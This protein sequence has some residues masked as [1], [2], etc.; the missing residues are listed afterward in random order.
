MFAHGE[1]WAIE[2]V[3]FV[4]RIAALPPPHLEHETLTADR[5]TPTT[6]T[7]NHAA[8]VNTAK[9]VVGGQVYT[10]SYYIKPYGLQRYIAS[11]GDVSA[12]RLGGFV[13]YD[14]VLGT[15]T[16]GSGATI[17][18]VGGGWFRVVQVMTAASSGNSTLAIILRNT[19]GANFESY[20]GV[21][22]NGFYLWGVQ[23]EDGA[24]ATS[25]ITTTTVAGVVT[26][27]SVAGSVAT[28]SPAPLD[29]ALLAWTGTD[30]NGPFNPAYSNAAMSSSFGS[31][32]V[33]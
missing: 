32:G 6:A 5:V 12:G 11:H 14:L 30:N 8:A 29:R 25:Y 2:I 16:G 27:Y 26:D 23:L 33:R 3:L 24:A 10:L 21:V 7:N 9:A 4:L 17:T 20:A 19:S 18:A 28:L 13:G 1:R 15:V 22:T 31:M